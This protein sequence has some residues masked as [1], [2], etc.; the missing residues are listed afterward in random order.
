MIIYDSNGSELLDVSVDDASFRHHAIKGD[1]TL[2]L[3]YSLPEHVELPRGAWCEYQGERYE[4]LNPEAIKMHHTRNFEYTVLFEA[5]QSRLKLWKFRNNVDGRLKFP[6]TATPREHLEM[7][8]AN[9]NA[10]DTGWMVGDCIDTPEKLVSYDHNSCWDALG[11]MAQEFATEWEIADKRISLRKVEYNK[12]NPLSLAYGFGKGLKTGVGRA[13]SGKTPAE[14][15]YVQ[16]G[17][18]NIDQTKYGAKTLHMPKGQ[19]IA[20]DGSKFEGE[21]GFVSA[22]ARRYKADAEGQSISRADKALETKAEDSISATEI[23]PSRIGVVGSVVAVNTEKNFY[24]V[25]DATIPDSLDFEKELIAGETMTIAFQ[26][27]QLAGR[28]F[29]VKYRHR[30]DSVRRKAA[31]RFEIIPQ[32]IDGVTMPS[33]TFKPKAGDKYAVFHVSLPKAYIADNTTRTGAEWELFK[34]AVRH[35]Y[36]NEDQKYTFTGELDGIWAKRDW[37]NIGGRLILGGYVSFRDD[38][39]ARDGV[40][41][42]IL[43]IKDFVN[44]PHSPILELSND[45]AST[46]FSGG[47]QKIKDDEAIVEEYH[48]DA[49]QFTKRRFRDAKET[50]V[51][52]IEAALDGFTGK[53]TPIVVQTMQLL[54]GDE[55]LQFRFVDNRT[56]PK[57][58]EHKVV[59]NKATRQLVLPAGTIQHLTMGIKTLSASHAPSEYKYWD[60]QA[61]TSARL[62]SPE[63][64]YY[65]Y[66]RVDANG[67]SGTFRLEERARRVDSEAGAYWLLL[68][69]LSAESDGERSFSTVYG[70]TEIL[71]GQIRTEKIATPDGSAYFDLVSGIIASKMIRFIHPDGSEHPYHHNDYLHK[72]IAD[73]STDILGGLLL[74]S[75][76]GAKD[77]KGIVRSYLAGDM[78][79]PAFAAGVTEFGK[80]AEKAVTEINHDGTGHI[81]NMHIDEGG[82]VIT[83]ASS[84]QGGATVRIGGSQSSLNDLINSSEQDS[85]TTRIVKRT[86]YQQLTFER[87]ERVLEIERFGLNVQNDGS[88]IYMEVP[89]NIS[90][91]HYNTN[92]QK[93]IS[94]AIVKV[95]IVNSA[96]EVVYENVEYLSSGNYGTHYSSVTY[97]LLVQKF[98]ISKGLYT[99]S[100]TA[101]VR[102]EFEPGSPMAPPPAY[103][104]FK[105]EEFALICRVM[106]MNESVRESVFSNKGVCIFF[107][108]KRFLFINGEGGD[109]D[110]FM[111][112]HGN[113]DMPGVLFSGDFW[114]SDYN[115]G[116]VWSED[117][118]GALFPNGL[119]C[120]RVG[121][122][123]YKIKHNL[124]R[125]NYTVQVCPIYR[126][127][128]EPSNDVMARVEFKGENS[129]NVVTGVGNEKS[130]YVPFSVLIIGANYKE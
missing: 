43:G 126:T 68:G 119:Y 97:P 121:F 25:I 81:G 52:L 17:D 118:F 89:W 120:E 104:V 125:S 101:R 41:L 51:A 22:N 122:G 32:E 79:K 50:A 67:T 73:G 100:I 107:G 72:A 33:E 39:F 60:I 88:S 58:V 24:D 20:F 124:G 13:S 113:T 115:G 69:L 35:L 98:G 6:L 28:E 26:S 23:Y 80:P 76:I 38:S 109:R 77:S 59:Y 110:I 90:V 4:L 55:S 3:K 46:S 70:F 86:V 85:S 47:L 45:V 87:E 48:K 129:F 83:F 123:Q 108:R 94:Y 27:G 49:I 130:N 111:T 65:V 91:E 61:L 44:A 117:S 53:I 93:I 11:K 71:P 92:S 95:Q 15:L 96:E 64:S 78:A 112:V 12:E 34:Y 106:G 31:K 84:T 116:N 19:T 42:R 54:V 66:A 75:L 18:R 82:S 37:V 8:V 57:K 14:I 5:R 62:D 21:E 16:G 99:V 1:H 56:A 114:P 128:Y 36:E 10:R 29:E 2:T 105:S 74:A 103:T 127:G 7:L 40:L 9:L 102:T 63:K 30:A